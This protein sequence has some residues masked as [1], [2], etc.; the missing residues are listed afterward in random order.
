[1]GAVKHLNS[2]NFDAETAKGVVL[3]DFW[4]EWCGPCRM[5]GPVLDDVAK[6]IGEDAVIAKVDVDEAQAVAMRFAVRSIPAIF[7]LK[8]GKTV[9][10]F[11]G[12]QG[13]Q[14]LVNAVRDALK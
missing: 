2:D 10:Q 14:V 8:D 13:K 7:I 11:V 12:V 4:A 5:L 6:E 1:M 3:V 9:Q